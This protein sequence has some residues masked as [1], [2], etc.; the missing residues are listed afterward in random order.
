MTDRYD[1]SGNYTQTFDVENRLVTVANSSNPDEVTRFEYDANGL[2]TKTTVEPADPPEL[3]EQRTI[4]YYPFPNY[5]REVRA[6]WQ[7][8]IK[9]PMWISTA[10]IYRSTYVAGGQIVAI[11]VSGDPVTGNNGLFFY[12]GD[13]LNSATFLTTTGGSVKSGTTRFYTPFGETRLGG[14]NGR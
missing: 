6:T 11:R 7:N 9:G 10:N 5:G 12:H 2:R 8:T 14:G 4:T 1:S 13:H 3:D